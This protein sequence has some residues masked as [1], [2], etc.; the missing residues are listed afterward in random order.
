MQLLYIADPLCSWC[1][2]FGPELDKLLAAHPEATLELT[3]GGLRPFNTE[4]MSDAFRDMLRGHW[5]H[6]AEAS[7][8]A[9][10][11][12]IFDTPGFVYD[13]EPPCRAVVTGRTLDAPRS[14]ALMKV[15]Q[16]AFYREGQDVTRPQRVSREPAEEMPAR[17]GQRSHRERPVTLGLMMPVMFDIQQVVDHVPAGCAEAER[18]EGQQCLPD[19]H[20]IPRPVRQQQR[21]QHQQVLHPLLRPQRQQD[22]PRPLR[23]PILRPIVHS[24]SSAEAE[25]SG[26]PPPDRLRCPPER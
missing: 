19:E 15:I 9:F 13:T 24:R 11:E 18:H 10:S 6:V 3:M 14:L 4:P 5:K 1:Y 25:Y 21:Q 16:L 8:L 23:R 20:G 26:T 22:G 2:G 12:A 7:G 17:D